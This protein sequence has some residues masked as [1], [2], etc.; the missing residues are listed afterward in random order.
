MR[1]LGT[2]F[3]PATFIFMFNFLSKF[4]PE[5]VK[6]NFPPK[7]ATFGRN[8]KMKFK[9]HYINCWLFSKL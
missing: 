6:L 8:C 5:S 4:F 7:G 9:F 2:Q 3:T 1:T